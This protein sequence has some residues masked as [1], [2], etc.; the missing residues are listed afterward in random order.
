MLY[1]LVTRQ[2]LGQIEGGTDFADAF[3]RRARARNVVKKVVQQVVDR[4]LVERFNALV[5]QPLDLAIGLPKQPFQRDRGFQPAVL[6]RLEHAADDPP[7]LV[8]I[9]PGGRA[10]ECRR[11]P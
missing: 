9:V 10:F 3:A 7:K 4:V 5:D 8:H 1:L 2:Q 6:Q 11:N